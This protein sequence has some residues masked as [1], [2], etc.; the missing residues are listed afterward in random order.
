LKNPRGMARKIR[1]SG[2]EGGEGQQ[3]GQGKI[4]L[5]TKVEPSTKAGILWES[6]AFL[7][8]LLAQIPFIINGMI[9]QII[10]EYV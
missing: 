6:L 5:L 9:I 10:I 8:F 1:D 4:E 3:K 2:K 7:G